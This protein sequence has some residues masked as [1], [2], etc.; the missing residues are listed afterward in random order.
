MDVELIGGDSLH[1]LWWGDSAGWT[2]QIEVRPGD[3]VDV[4]SYAETPP[5]VARNFTS[6]LASQAGLTFDLAED[7]V[8]WLRDQS[9]T[10]FIDPYDEPDAGGA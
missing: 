2:V 10:R 8:M 1:R 9:P 6:W 4:A 3:W 5:L 7:A